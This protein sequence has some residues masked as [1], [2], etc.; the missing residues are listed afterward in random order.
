VRAQWEIRRM[1]AMMRAQIKH[2]LPEIAVFLQPKCGE[3]R[4]GYCDESL[5]DW[6]KCPLGRVRPHK[7]SLFELYERHG[8]R[9][10]EALGEAEFR[11][12]EEKELL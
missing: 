8:T 6:Q 2:V 1:V 5:E 11:A 3:N 4:M 7:S 12:V 9:K 10:A